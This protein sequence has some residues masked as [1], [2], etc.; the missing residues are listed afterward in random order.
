MKTTARIRRGGSG[1]TI[2]EL[3][4]VMSIIMLM[5]GLG[6]ASFRFFD[7]KDPFEEPASKLLQM[8][9]FALHS[10]AVQHRGR[11]IGFDKTGFGLLGGGAGVGEHY[12][13]PK[14]MKILIFRMGAKSWDN[15]EG[16]DWQFGEQGIC[17]P[18][19]VRFEMNG[20]SREVA[21]HPLTGTPVEY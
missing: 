12:A 2:L 8:S 19:K 11:T 1:F 4:V 7:E 14:D 10:A 16:H 13:V 17:E 18:V 15:A 21:F 9:K 3:V 20:E 6:I 5:I